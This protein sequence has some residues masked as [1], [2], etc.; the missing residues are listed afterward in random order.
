MRAAPNH[1]VPFRWDDMPPK[2]RELFGA[3]PMA[4]RYDPSDRINPFYL[5]GDFDGD[6]KPDY[7]VLIKAK[8]HG[9]LGFA[10]W[11]N[12]RTTPIILGA[13]R[14]VRYGSGLEEDLDFDVW[15]VTSPSQFDRSSFVDQPEGIRWDCIYV[16]KGEGASGIYFFKGGSFHWLQQG[17]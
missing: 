16:Q 12:A 8:S 5:R 15:R 13:G 9:K 1:E 14:R 17:D 4:S 2:L 3:P 6:G 10:V 7:A 11:L